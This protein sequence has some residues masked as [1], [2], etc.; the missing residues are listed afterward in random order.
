MTYNSKEQSEYDG[1]PVELYEIEIPGQTFLYTNSPV[2]VDGYTPNQIGRSAISDTTDF[3]DSYTVDIYIPF[4]DP[5]AD[6]FKA[7]PVPTS[8]FVTVRRRHES[9]EVATAYIGEMIGFS[10]DGKTLTLHT[11]LA[12]LGKFEYERNQPRY[13][14]KCNNRVYDNVCGLNQADFTFTATITGIDGDRYTLDTDNGYDDGRLNKGYFTHNPS[15]A[16][17]SIVTHVGNEI[18]T[19]IAVEGVDVGD[20]L[21]IYPGCQGTFANCQLF[22]NTDRFNGFIFQVSSSTPGLAAFFGSEVFAEP[23]AAGEEV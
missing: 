11:K 15:G 23:F 13:Q 22:E 14:P 19:N 20:T 5:L 10:A 7:V 18:R 3:D 8:C 12:N 16:F 21:D 9:T 1:A 2:A 17:R 4:Y 6:L